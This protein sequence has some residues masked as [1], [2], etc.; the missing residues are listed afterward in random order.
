MSE[1][2]LC[3]FCSP[4]KATPGRRSTAG[5]NIP[6]FSALKTQNLHLRSCSHQTLTGA[7]VYIAKGI[8]GGGIVNCKW[9]LCCG[10]RREGG[11]ANLKIGGGE[12]GIVSNTRYWVVTC[13]HV[14]SKSVAGR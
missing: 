8:A 11:I 12:G 1:W 7:R 3:V 4:L 14:K 10:L 2:C 6:K 13:L 5:E 9:Y